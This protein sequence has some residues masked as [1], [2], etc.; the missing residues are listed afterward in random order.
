MRSR[1]KITMAT[2]KKNFSVREINGG[3]ILS[4]QRTLP[5]YNQEEYMCTDIDSLLTQIRAELEK[6]AEEIPQNP[7]PQLNGIAA[8]H[9]G[10]IG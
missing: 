4:V 5:Y 9:A 1:N 6:P 10:N 7:I 2:A 8:S 3:Y